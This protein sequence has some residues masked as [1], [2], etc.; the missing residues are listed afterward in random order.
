[1]YATAVAKLYHKK[2]IRL[3]IIYTTWK[4]EFCAFQGASIKTFNFI[5]SWDMVILIWHILI[6]WEMVKINIFSPKTTLSEPQK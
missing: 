2:K 5:W 4:S 6:F 1:V 3:N